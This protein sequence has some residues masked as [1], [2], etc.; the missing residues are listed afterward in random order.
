MT[1]DRQAQKNTWDLHNAAI[2]DYRAEMRDL[3]RSH[4][5]GRPRLIAALKKTAILF[6]AIG[7]YAAAADDFSKLALAL[8]DAERG[9]GHPLID[10]APLDYGRP[11]ERTDKWKLRVDVIVAIEFLIAGGRPATRA[12]ASAVQNH[13]GLEKLLQEGAVLSTSLK[14]WLYS[15]RDERK[16]I[17]FGCPEARQAYVDG[18]NILKFFKT[19]RPKSQLIAIGEANLSRAERE[20]ATLL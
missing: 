1:Q 3:Y 7:D 17:Q 16:L 2:R 5:T 9:R 14:H 6:E 11:P 18:M 10:P 19:E 13:P 4:L 12:F 15:L 20:A 8:S